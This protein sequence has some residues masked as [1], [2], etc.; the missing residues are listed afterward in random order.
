MK[1][2]YLKNIKNDIIEYVKENKKYLRDEEQFNFDGLYDELFIEDAITGNASGSYYCNTWKAEE[3]LAHN[4]DLLQEALEMFGES[5]IN[6]LEKGAEWCDV[7]IRCYLL[8]QAIDELKS[9]ILDIL[10]LGD[11]YE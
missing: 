11:E 6:A 4:M 7:T 8:G 9:E 2:N 5:D 1:Y 3:A 10:E